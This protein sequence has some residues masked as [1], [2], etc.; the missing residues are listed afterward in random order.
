M[1]EIKF[2]YG[3]SDGINLFEKVFT[4]SDIEQGLQFDEICDSPLMKDYK[5]VHRRQYT[6]LKD[7][8]DVEIYEGDIIK[9]GHLDGWSSETWHRV[10]VVELFPALQFKIL[11]Y[12]DSKTLD[13]KPA[14]NYVFEFGRFAY[15][16]THKHIKVIGNI[17]ENS[18]LL[19]G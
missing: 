6:G 1:R 3:Y 19:N 7:K 2:K 17:Y 14:D 18:E 16:D 5:I 9:W 8:N 4:L 10:A 13:K 15:K 12:I 11:H